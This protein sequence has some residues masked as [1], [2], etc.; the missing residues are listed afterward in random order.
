[1]SL[2]QSF[3]YFTLIKEEVSSE[4]SESVIEKIDQFIHS[5]DEAI[6]LQDLN[7]HRP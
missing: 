1:L 5:L 6:N 2:K 3:S 4:L 7:E